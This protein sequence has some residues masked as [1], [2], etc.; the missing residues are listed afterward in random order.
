MLVF[1]VLRMDW[2]RRKL[3]LENKVTLKKFASLLLMIVFALLSAN[4]SLAQGSK[5]N[6]KLKRIAKGKQ[7]NIVYILLDDQRYDAMGFLKGQDFLETPNMDSIAKNGTYLP[8]AFV[9]TSLCS[10]SRASIL[11]GQYAHRHRVVDNDSPLPDGLTFF[12]Q[13]LQK[14]GYETAFIGKWHMGGGS[15]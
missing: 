10:P 1:D 15:G 9:T 11:T 12:P 5:T 4:I 13:Y 6:L 8:N 2:N 7:Y 3:M 14:A